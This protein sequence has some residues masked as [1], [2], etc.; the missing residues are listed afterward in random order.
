[1]TLDFYLG[2]FKLEKII[3]F[4]LEKKSSFY[5]FVLSKIFQEKIHVGKGFHKSVH[6]FLSMP[7]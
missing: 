6:V 1:M 3:I 2:P 5:L 4:L 7:Q